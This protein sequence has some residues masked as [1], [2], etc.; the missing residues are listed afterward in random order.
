MNVLFIVCLSGYSRRGP[1]TQSN[2]LLG[3]EV[4]PNHSSALR[5]SLALAEFATL[6]QRGGQARL[7]R[8]LQEY[9]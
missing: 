2:Y 6:E 4:S 8:S 9:R 3:S 7:L 5:I 1:I